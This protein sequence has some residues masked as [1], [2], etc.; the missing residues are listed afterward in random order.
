MKQSEIEHRL[1]VEARSCG[2]T[3]KHPTVCRTCGS[4]DSA[5]GY[6]EHTPMRSTRMWRTSRIGICRRHKQSAGSRI[7]W[8]EQN[9]T[10]TKEGDKG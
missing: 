4:P 9:C 1:I 7:T 5:E 8:Y 10:A 3:P 2:A 6:Y